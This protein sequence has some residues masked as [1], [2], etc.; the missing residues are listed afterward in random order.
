MNWITVYHTL[1]LCGKL[2]RA[3]CRVLEAHAH[4]HPPVI[5]IAPP[6][7]GA[8]PT[9]GYRAPPPRRVRVPVLCVAHL[10]G[11]RVEWFAQEARQ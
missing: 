3:G 10:G 4:R 7:A 1:T 6:P 5:K 9:Y 8:L 2:T 11:A